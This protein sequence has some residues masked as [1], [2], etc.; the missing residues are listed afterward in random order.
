MFTH[1]AMFLY[2]SNQPENLFDLLK[3]SQ[4]C[5]FVGYFIF[6]K[7]VWCK[8]VHFLLLLSCCYISNSNDKEWIHFCFLISGLPYLF[9]WMKN[10]INF[11]EFYWTYLTNNEHFSS[12]NSLT[13][14]WN[15]QNVSANVASQWPFLLDIED[16]LPPSLNNSHKILYLPL[17]KQK[18]H[19]AIL[20]CRWGKYINLIHYLSS[21]FSSLCVL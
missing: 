2:R 3:I 8:S 1:A 5:K 18:T 13:H 19:I 11:Q 7:T 6:S 14:N 16:I 12:E 20:L 10:K 4:V 9:C 21:T 17:S 15:M